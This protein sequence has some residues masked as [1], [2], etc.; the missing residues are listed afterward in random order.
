MVPDYKMGRA[1]QTEQNQNDN[2]QHCNFDFV[3]SVELL[4]EKEVLFDPSLG[5]NQYNWRAP[6][7]GSALH[8]LIWIGS[9]TARCKAV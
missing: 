4:Q 3:L 6:Y 8:E 2:V 9:L 5:A 1:V 7:M